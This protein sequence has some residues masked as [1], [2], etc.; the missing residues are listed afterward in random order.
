VTAADFELWS[1][2]A[3]A[4]NGCGKCVDSHEKVLLGKNITEET[5]LASVRV[6]SVI[7]AIGTVLDAQR[8]AALSVP[9]ESEL[10]AV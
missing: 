5:I 3:S 7:H 10:A 1:L 2:A 6:A 4:I 8:V 9:A